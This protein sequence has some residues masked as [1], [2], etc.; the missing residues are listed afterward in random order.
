MKNR[1]VI[2]CF[3]MVIILSLCTACNGTVTRDIRHAGFAV[4]GSF[5]CDRFYPK[6]KEDTSY[7][8][9]LYFTGSHLINEKGKIY[10]LSLGQ[11]FANNQNCKEAETSLTVKAIMDDKLIKATDDK[12][13][14]LFTQN[15]VPSYTEVPETDNA[16]AI[17]DLLLN[18][19]DIVK[20]QTAD[21]SRGLYYILKTDGNIYGNIISTQDR[22]SPPLVTSTQIVYNKSD[23]GA[24]IIDFN[25]AGDSLSTYV[26]TEEKIFRMRITNASKC[27]K[28]ADIP[29]EF[30]MMEDPIFEQYKDRIIFFNGSTLIT[31]YKMTFGVAN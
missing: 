6:D 3:M 20:V 28:Y 21:S 8:K 16:Y 26:K 23:Y 9:I 12:Y 7:D 17:Y 29:C 18:D 31:D 27:Q 25:Y 10:E 2:Y 13:Y 24:R 11:T 14:Y 4:G 1:K 22:N 15:N 19:D 30:S 5:V